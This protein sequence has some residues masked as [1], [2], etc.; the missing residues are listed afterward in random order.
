MLTQKKYFSQCIGSVDALN[1]HID[2]MQHYR[3]HAWYG[4][5]IDVTVLKGKVSIFLQE[6]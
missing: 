5:P 3:G 6:R 4:L 2:V 1:I